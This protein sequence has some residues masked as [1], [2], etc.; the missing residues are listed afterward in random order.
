MVKY[1]FKKHIPIEMLYDL[2]DKIC[3]KNPKYYIMDF[4]AYRLLQYH[5]LYEPFVA[6]ILAYYQPSKQ[7]YLTR[8][9][10]YNSFITVVRQICKINLIEFSNRFNYQNSLY[11][12]DYYIYRKGCEEEE[13][14]VAE[15]IEAATAAADRT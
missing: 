12:I 1:L 9:L 8:T 7:Y 2:L 15:A 3:I 6:T 5:E 4:N 14:A 13:A 11:N 10:T